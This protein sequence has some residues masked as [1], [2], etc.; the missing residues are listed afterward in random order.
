VIRLIVQQFFYK[1][2]HRTQRIG[3]YWR[4]IN[5]YEDQGTC[6][7]CHETESMSHILTQCSEQN[8]QEVW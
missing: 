2:L 6:M 8:M 1:L 7:T 3:E 4:N 5:G